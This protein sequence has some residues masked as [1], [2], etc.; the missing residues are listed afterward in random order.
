M[1]ATK[2]EAQKRQTARIAARRGRGPA[3]SYED[4]S[5]YD[6]CITRGLPG[7][8]TPAIYGNAYDITQGPGFVAIRYEMIHETRIIPLDGRPAPPSSI[9]SY[10]GEPRGRWDG[11]T[12][13]VVWDHLDQPS[14]VIALDKNTGKELWRVDHPEMD[15]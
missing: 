13:V 8:M 12:L 5:L 10:M 2:P 3:D 7:S 11:N 4:R 14:Y 6:R 1:P 15:T 9:R